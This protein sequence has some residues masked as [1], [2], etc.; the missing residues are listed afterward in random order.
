M[1]P[2][3]IENPIAEEDF[4]TQFEIEET[5]RNEEAVRREEEKRR[6]Y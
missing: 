2:K 1:N 5:I 4:R 3:H 6:K